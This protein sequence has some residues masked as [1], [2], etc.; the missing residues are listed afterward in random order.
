M[1]KLIKN[2]RFVSSCSFLAISSLVVAADTG[3]ERPNIIVFIADDAGMDFGCYG[4]KTIKTPNIDELAE[5]GIRFEKAFV[6]S[7]QSSPSRTSM[8]TGLFAHTLGTEDLHTPI[9]SNTIIMPSYFKETG[10]I[11]AFMLKTHW[12]K[13]GD[14][15]FDYKIKGGI[16]AESGDITEETFRNYKQFITDCGN[17]PFFLWVGFHDPHRPYNRK[18]CTQENDPSHVFVPPF[19]IDGTDTRRDIADYYDEIT[20]MDKNVGN[21]VSYLEEK[22]ML[23]N[24]VI[25][26][27]SDNGM[28]FPRAKGTLY[29]SGIQTPLIFMWRNKIKK[30]VVHHNGL[31]STIDLA[32]TLLEL[33][34]V[35]MK[36]EVYGESFAPLLF[37][38]TLRGRDCIFAERNWHNSDEYIRC[39]RTENFKLIYNAYYH[40]PHGT[41]TDL[42]TSL[43]WYELKKK[44]KKGELKKEQIQIFESPRPM[45][46]IYDLEK[47]PYELNNVAD[48]QAYY[49]EGRKLARLLT[50]WQTETKDHPWWRRRRA[51]QNDRITGFPMFH[52]RDTLWID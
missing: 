16:C 21:M 38:H 9:D 27:L 17:R 10:Y 51:D 7:P 8:M 40:L 37:D 13:N 31:I 11:T 20:R 41:A 2:N 26:F 4:N 25:V 49:E 6:T 42:S 44:Q 18:V 34:G 43:S 30:N 35:K 3:M 23:D 5:E 39:V 50:D 1:V 36:E 48:I 32:P 24:T 14:D 15:Q 19:L 12:G 28:P 46:E 45:V 47:D 52:E 33:A 29:D 22:R